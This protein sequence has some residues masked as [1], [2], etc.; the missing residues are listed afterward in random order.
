MEIHQQL[1]DVVNLRKGFLLEHTENIDE[2]KDIMKGEYYRKQMDS[3]KY[4]FDMIEK[5]MRLFSNCSRIIVE[6][7]IVSGFNV[8]YGNFK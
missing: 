5:F 6:E 2:L 1:E 4:D 3:L 7:V 8:S